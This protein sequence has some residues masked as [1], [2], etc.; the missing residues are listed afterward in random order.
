MHE[1]TLARSIL[2]A[3]LAKLPTDA[4]MLVRAVHGRVAE[5]ETLSQA[6]LALHFGA[7]ARG[8]PADGAKL[9]FELVHV[10]ARC[11]GC[12]E[13]YLPE[14]HLTLCPSCGSTEAEV[15]GDTGLTVDHVE[16]VPA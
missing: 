2:E 6:S 10:S 14:H 7:V 9:V 12:G 15:L 8:T 13:T 5:T 3:V 11:K 16:V 4:P 1:S